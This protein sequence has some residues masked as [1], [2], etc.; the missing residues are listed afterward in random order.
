MKSFFVYYFLTLLFY[1]VEISLFSIFYISWRYDIFW[2]NI[3]LRSLLVIIFSILIRNLIFTT[4]RHF[5]LKFFILVLFNPLLSSTILK[6]FTLPL[7][8]INVLVLKFF[9]DLI[10]SILI[11]LILKKIS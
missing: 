1:L 6:L 5:Y 2:L 3:T 9:A 7:L 11:F 4:I 10:T 8:S